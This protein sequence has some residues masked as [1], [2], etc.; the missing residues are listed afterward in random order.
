MSTK[1]GRILRFLALSVSGIA[2][3]AHAQVPAASPA[4]STTSAAPEYVRQAPKGA[5][6][7]VLVL[8]DDVGFGAPSTFGG[9]AQTT[10]LDRLARDGLRYN[11][12]HTTAICS[13]TRASLLTGRNPHAAGIGAVMN[14]SDARPGYSNSISVTAST[15][16]SL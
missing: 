2:T 10:T 13:P 7:I 12:F 11:R 1:S 3:M 9:P 5:P 14:S 4:P 8:L 16:P 6:N 15:A